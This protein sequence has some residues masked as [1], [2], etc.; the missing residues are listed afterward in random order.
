MITKLHSDTVAAWAAELA[1]IAYTTLIM[2]ACIMIAYGG[3]N[4]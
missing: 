2:V 1:I 4:G 3:Y